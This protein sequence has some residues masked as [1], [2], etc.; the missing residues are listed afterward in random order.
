MGVVQ[1]AELTER[2]S[3]A[4]ASVGYALSEVKLSSQLY[5]TDQMLGITAILYEH[6]LNFF[7]R[8]AKWYTTSTTGRI[9]RSFAWPFK[10]EYADI[11]GKIQECSEYARR[12]A[13]GQ[14]KV[15]LR[16][17]CLELGKMGTDVQGIKK[18]VQEL[19]GQ[20]LKLDQIIQTTTATHTLGEGIKIRVDDTASHVAQ[21]LHPNLL[22]ELKPAV[23]PEDSLR[24][25]E[26][27]LRRSE[28]R[29][30][31]SFLHSSVLTELTQWKSL[32]GSSLLILQPG[33]RATAATKDLVVN[34]VSHIKSQQYNVLWSLSQPSSADSCPSP[35]K[36]L[37]S[38]VYQVLRQRPDALAGT[39]DEHNIA[40][41]GDAHTPTEWLDLLSRVIPALGQCFVVVESEDL[42]RLSQGSAGGCRGFLELFRELLGRM[43]ARGVF[44]KILVVDFERDFS[45]ASSQSSSSSSGQAD[46]IVATVRRRDTVPPSRRRTVGQMARSR[47]KVFDVASRRNGRAV[48]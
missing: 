13:S 12:I 4:L 36:V 18:V 9:A 35:E 48:R 39:A 41:F 34:I 3:E 47:S 29:T 15:E 31:P 42:H 2:L 24:R 8:T 44:V 37:K 6:I 11:L 22:N 28:R 25:R 10:L 7:L 1:Y 33:A 19:Q 17:I 45:L 20:H 43:Q 21:I 27:T 5:P 38:L 16:S 30:G 46:Q 40:K 14:S 26:Y 23:R 32:P